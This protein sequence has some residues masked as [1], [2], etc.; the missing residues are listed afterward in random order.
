MGKAS[1]KACAE[2]SGLNKRLCFNKYKPNLIKF[3]Y[4]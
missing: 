1:K 3:P 2:A 4:S